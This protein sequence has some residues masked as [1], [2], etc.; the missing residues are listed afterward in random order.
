MIES[1]LLSSS[2]LRGKL[3]DD[4]TGH[5]NL[6]EGLNTLFK[7]VFRLRRSV[8]RYKLGSS[9]DR[10]LIGQIEGKS[11]SLVDR[12]VRLA[13][14]DSSGSGVKIGIASGDRASTVVAR[15]RS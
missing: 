4:W 11:T 10:S 3:Q 2:H 14:P 7:V 1:C 15:L 13:A 6:E 8:W 12:D 5:E 9:H